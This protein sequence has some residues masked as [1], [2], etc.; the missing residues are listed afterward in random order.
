[1][2]KVLRT[3]NFVALTPVSVDIANWGRIHKCIC[4]CKYVC[5]VYKYVG[6]NKLGKKKTFKDIYRV[7]L[8]SF[9]YS[10]DNEKLITI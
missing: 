10:S 3:T 2:P 8:T 7:H 5:I 6:V 9:H 1:M 4:T